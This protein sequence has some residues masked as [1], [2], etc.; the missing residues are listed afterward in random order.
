MNKVVA[1]VIDNAAYVVASVR[2]NGWKLI[3]CFAHTL[4]LLVQDSLAADPTLS[5]IQKCHDIESYFH[6]SCKATERLT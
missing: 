3:P 2:L 1:V 5:G 6:H 4:N